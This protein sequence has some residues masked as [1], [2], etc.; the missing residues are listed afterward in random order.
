MTRPDDLDEAA[1][2]R[3][4]PA[5]G[6]LDAGV[7]RRPPS[8]APSFGETVEVNVVNVEVYVTDRKGNRVTG[9][10]KEDFDLFEDGKRVEIVNFDA[11]RTAGGAAGRLAARRSSGG[12]AIRGR[13]PG[14]WWSSSTTPTSGP[15]TGPGREQ[16]RRLPRPARLAP[17]DRVL[18]ATYDLGLHVRVPFTSDP[19]ALDQ[20]PAGDRDAGGPRRRGGTGR[21]QAVD[22]ILDELRGRPGRPLTAPIPCPLDVA[23]PARTYPPPAARRSC[24][25]SAALTVLINSLSGVPGRKA[26]LHVS[27]GIPLTPGEELFQFLPELCGR[28][29]TGETSEAPG[30]S[31]R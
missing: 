20:R 30:P 9:L 21:A 6:G 12:A 26:L 25:P 15:R 27:D 29:S 17:G 18:L 11:R 19:A 8:A 7:L 10:K 3:R 22:S 31:G 23:T 1:A 24:G 28:G 16:L 13:R 2:P 14:P 4:R 5:A